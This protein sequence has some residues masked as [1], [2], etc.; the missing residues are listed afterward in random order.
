MTGACWLNGEFVA[1]EEARVSPM[2]RGFLF[3]DGIYEVVPVYNRRRFLPERHWARMRRS[4]S[5]TRMELDPEALL[6]A[7]SREVIARQ[8]FADQA[9]YIQVTRGASPLRSHAFGDGMSPTLFIASFPMKSGDAM[10][11]TRENGI[12]CATHDDFRW[13]RGDIKS[14][15]LLGAALLARSAK[16]AGCEE[17]VLIRDGMLTEGSS[18][19]ILMVKDGVLFSPKFDERV[20]RGITCEVVLQVARDSGIEVM[21][22]DIHRPE[23]FNADELWL[24]SSTK[25]M[26][27]IVQLDGTPVGDARP[28]KIFARVHKH[29]QTFRNTN[30]E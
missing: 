29:F 28:G 1:P 9:L 17:A 27:P 13:L 30:C 2:D 4:L 26:L 7:P 20:L 15:A 11:E 24:T 16:D 6:D 21:Q 8:D 12:A 22:R 3:G 18:S 19:N 5:A 25:E 10:R 14:T 23:L